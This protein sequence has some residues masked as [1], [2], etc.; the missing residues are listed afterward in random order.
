[1][2]QPKSETDKLNPAEIGSHFT[3]AQRWLVKSLLTL[4][5][6]WVT[7]ENPEK[8]TAIPGPAIFAFNH[9][10]TFETLLVPVYLFSLLGE[11]KFS[12]VVDWMF[13]QIPGINW[14][15]K[16]IDPIYVYN[17]PSTLTWLNSIRH[18]PGHLPALGQCLARLQQGQSL[19]LFPEGTR[20]RNPLTLLKAKKGLGHLVLQSQVPVIPIGIDFPNRTKL[21][22]IPAFGPLIIR[23]GAPLRFNTTRAVPQ[24][25]TAAPHFPPAA[26]KKIQNI[27]AARITH[28]IMRQIAQL[29]G[30]RYP[31]PSP[32]LPPDLQPWSDAIFANQT[33][34]GGD[35]YGLCRDSNSQNYYSQ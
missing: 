18:R 4:F 16:Q 25:I 9:N 34:E 32:V 12:F 19:G 13:G 27:L 22:K 24:E 14:F 26:L 28:Q 7:V 31:Y 10:N 2:M 3:P 20:N 1:M 5:G 29:S 33:D 6:G 21:R 23:I 35:N 11:Q 15:L 8:L 30:K 17:K